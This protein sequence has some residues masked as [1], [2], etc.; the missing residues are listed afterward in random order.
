MSN[1]VSAQREPTNHEIY[2]RLIEA[3]STSVVRLLSKE[4]HWLPIGRHCCIGNADWNLGNEEQRVSSLDDQNVLEQ[5][6]YA[7]FA[8]R[9]PLRLLR[10]T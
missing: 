8:S 2:T 1:S 4:H 10:L 7:Q 9:T 5:A 6:S 3:L